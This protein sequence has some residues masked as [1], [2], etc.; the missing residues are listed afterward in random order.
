MKVAHFIKSHKALGDIHLKII[1]G[2]VGTS[3]ALA[4]KQSLEHAAKMTPEQL[5]LQFSRYQSKLK[6]LSLQ[7]MIVLNEQLVLWLQSQKYKASDA[8]KIRQ[9]A[10]AYLQYLRKTKN[11]ETL[12]HFASM[13]D[14]P[15]FERARDM[16]Y[17]ATDLVMLLMEYIQGI[18]V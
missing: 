15:K 13:V 16:L 11:H 9:N 3:A 1:A 10:L 14:N 4:L 6:D 12:A 17:E 8:D 7:D 18:K 2:M 5:L